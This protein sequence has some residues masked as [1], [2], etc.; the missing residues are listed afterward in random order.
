V[1]AGVDREQRVGAMVVVRRRDVDDVDL[2]V[3]DQIG[4]GAVRAG[5][6][7]SVGD[8][9]AEATERDPTATTR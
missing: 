5:D 1:F 8:P 9:R 4:V 6:P 2:R 3:G 7:G